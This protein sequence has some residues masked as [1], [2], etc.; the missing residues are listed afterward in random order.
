MFKIKKI[1]DNLIDWQI[2][3][4]KNYADTMRYSVIKFTPTFLS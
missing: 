1:F 4:K 3:A 2:F